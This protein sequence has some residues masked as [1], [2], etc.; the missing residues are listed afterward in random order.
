MAEAIKIS[1]AA[2]RINANL[3]QKDVA[4]RLKVTNNTIVAWENGTSEPKVSQAI[5]LSEL[6]GIP[7]DNI[8]FLPVKSNYI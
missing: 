2:A 5:A 1:L 3:T 4:E 6:Y 8:I 7:F